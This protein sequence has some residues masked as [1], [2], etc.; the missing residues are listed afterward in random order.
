[1]LPVPS[2]YRPGQKWRPTKRHIGALGA[3]LGGMWAHTKRD[4]HNYMSG[5]DQWDEGSW[6]VRVAGRGDGPPG[7]NHLLMPRKGRKRYAKRRR[8]KT[9]RKG[10][11]YKRRRTS[12]RGSRFTRS[13]SRAA[14]RFKIN[15]LINP[16]KTIKLAN[17]NYIEEVA[18]TGKCI[19]FMP[20]PIVDQYIM[21][22]WQ[23]SKDNQ[24]DVFF[25]SERAARAYQ[26]YAG[27]FNK[28]T[29]NTDYDFFVSAIEYMPRYDYRDCDYTQD[30]LGTSS[31]V[32]MDVWYHSQ[33]AELPTLDDAL[34]TLTTA[35]N[36][37][38]RHGAYVTAPS[39]ATFGNRTFNELFKPIKTYKPRKVKPGDE[40]V[41][42]LQDRKMRK[43]IN[44][45]HL[46]NTT[47]H[48]PFLTAGRSRFIMFKVWG[49][50]VGTSETNVG[51][52]ED[53]KVSSSTFIV[54]HEYVNTFTGKVMPDDVP[55]KAF[56]DFRPSIDPANQAG[57]V[58]ADMDIDVP[59]G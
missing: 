34:L 30:L 27:Q 19:F 36:T 42:R 22:T 35:D 2:G 14:L 54:H 37:N 38:G 55:A 53:E 46:Y 33:R 23:E 39:Y 32:V 15:D 7:I 31:N 40:V 50:T 29:N 43:M 41:Y 1:M 18:A 5:I 16:P 9:P 25:G 12:S 11:R 59:E 24:D 21:R 58:D 51:A 10:R 52:L 13:N 44:H 47:N 49:K 56:W 4:A 57:I 3:V 6:K 28:I 45:V 20:P 48:S 26:V 8:T 17:Y